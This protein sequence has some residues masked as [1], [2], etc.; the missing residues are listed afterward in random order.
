MKRTLSLVFLF[1][2]VAVLLS[3]GISVDTSRAAESST[4]TIA[5]TGN[6]M[7][8]LEPCGWADTGVQ[9]GGLSKKSTIL[10]QYRQS[11]LVVVDSGDLFNEDEELP[12]SVVE[13]AKLKAEAIAQ[14]CNKIGIDAVNVGELDLVLGIDFLKGL[15]S[16]EKFPLISANLVDEKGAPIFKPY[17]IKNV[18][19]KRIGIFGVMGDTSEMAEKVSQLSKGAAKVKDVLETA[20]SVVK[21]LSG[22]TDYIIALTHQGTNRN[23]VIARRVQGIDLVVGGHDKQKTKEPNEAGKAIIVQAG[24][25]G[26]YVGLLEVT[27]DG[28][29]TWKNTLQPLGDEI[30][31]DAAIK[32]MISDYNDK[33]AALYG[34]ESSESKTAPS[35]AT[36]RLTACEPC[37]SEAVTK[38]KTTDHAKAYETLVS[39]SKQFDP[40]CLACHTT[41]FEQ[42]EGFSMKQ[43]QMELVNVQCESCHGFAKDH[44]ATL[45]PIPNKK[46]EIALCIKCHTADR[47]PNFEQDADKVFAKIKH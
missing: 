27:M 38:W 9:L 6:M 29:K 43:Q 16:K 10:N 1:L 11:G 46:P 15:E 22:K 39:R 17:V 19:G 36:L 7:G 13:G 44:L 40:K 33:V 25:K 2:G 31:N 42:P 23:W 47:C 34:G 5:Y 4:I 37:H 20:E 21:E 18:N 26:Q 41:R 35:A 24:E 8:Y 3:I 28:T 12:E 32:K 45:Q 14:I 30:A